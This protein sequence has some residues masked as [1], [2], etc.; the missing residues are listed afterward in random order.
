MASDE[1]KDDRETNEPRN[2]A[3]P[4]RRRRRRG[5]LWSMFRALR[6]TVAIFLILAAAVY[7][8]FETSSAGEWIGDVISRQ[9]EDGL[10]RSVSV[11][12]VSLWPTIPARLVVRDIRIANAPGA[13]APDFASV[14][15]IEVTGLLKSLAERRIDLGTIRVLHPKI[16]IEMMP[17]GSTIEDNIP[18][19]K[20]SGEDTGTTAKIDVQRILLQD[21]EVELID[22]RHDI[23]IRA[24]GITA[25]LL[26]DVEAKT[27]T[28]TIDA[29]VVRA[30]TGTVKYPPAALKTELAFASDALRF[31]SIE[32]T[33]GSAL[34]AEGEGR[35]GLAGT[36]SVDFNVRGNVDLAG[37]KNAFEIPGDVEFK[38]R[39]NATTKI[40]VRDT[41]R[42]TGRFDLPEVK[43]DV[44]EVRDGKGHF[45]QNDDGFS[46]NIDSGKFAGG[47]A[48]VEFRAP[49]KG[50]TLSVAI[51]H[52]DVRL[53]QLLAI[54][55]VESS[56][57]LG[58]ADGTLS[59]SW[60][61][62]DLL[63][64]T[65]KGEATLTADTRPASRAKYPLP[66]AGSVSYTI[67]GKKIDFEP[68]AIQTPQ[69]AVTITGTLGLEDLAT[70]L[71]AQV[72]SRNFAELDRI[73][74]DFA[75]ALGEK[76]FELL[77]L[78]GAGEI[79]AVVTGTLE[80]P[81]ADAT[82]SAD[83]F[84]YA[85]APLGHAE[86]DLRYDVPAE[87]LTFRR[88]T[89][90]A[91]GGTLELGKTIKL[92]PDPAEVIFDLD[93]R[94]DGWPV[95]RALK[96]IDLTLPISGR[97]TGG[98]HVSGRPSTG[99]VN[100]E[101]LAIKGNASQIRLNGL[102]GWTPAKNGLTFNLD[103]AT[104][105]TPVADIARLLELGEPPL[106]GGV[107]GTV[108]L[109][110]PLEKISGAG[111][112]AV[113]DGTISGEPFE[114]LT[115]DLVFDSGTVQVKNLDIRLAAGAIRG[116][117]AYSLSDER[118][119]FVVQS[120]SIDLKKLKGWPAIA[121][122]AEGTLVFSASGAGTAEHPEIVL[123][124]KVE[125]AKIAGFDL[126]SQDGVQLYFAFKPQG[127]TLRANVG[128]A[129][130]IEGTGAIDAATS[131]LRGSVR[132]SADAS[133]PL[134]SEISSRSDLPTKGK[135]AIDLEIAG[136]MKEIDKATVT[137]TVSSL[138]I[139]VATHTIRQA[140]R[141]Q[142]AIHDGKLVFDSFR[143]MFD[144]A[145]FRVDGTISLADQTVDILL[146]GTLNAELL[147]YVA[148]D[149]RAKGSIRISMAVSG[150]LDKPRIR[151]S[152]D[153]RDGEVRLAG[154]T[155]V[156]KEIN[157]SIVFRE[158]E[159]RIDS[160]N[161]N[162]GGGRVIAGGTINIKDAAHTQLRIS[163]QG[164]NVQIRPISDISTTGSFE[165]V[166]AGDLSEKIF[167][168]GKVDLSRV[169]VT[170]NV[171]VSGAMVDVFLKKKSTVTSIGAP[172]QERLLLAVDVSTRERAISIRNNLADM[173][174]SGDVRVTGSF[175]NPIVLGRIDLDEGGTFELRD[176]EYRIAHGQVNFQNPFRTDP[177]FDIT[178]ESRYQ[179][180]YDLTISLTGTI[181]RLDTTI[182]SDPPI[183][184]LSLLTLLGATG[185]SE[186]AKSTS[187]AL[188]EAGGSLIDKSVA[189][190]ISARVPFA[191]AVRLEGVTGP[192]P[193]VTIEKAISKE[194]R[195]I[196]TYTLNNTADNSEIVEWRVSP[197]LLILFTRDS[198]KDTRYGITSV[199]L[200]IRKRYGGVR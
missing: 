98:M 111:S 85:N 173:T 18:R 150:K 62:A 28:G 124:A 86:I 198:T 138:D 8:L 106:S 56:G 195:A 27:A 45:E 33:S 188:S 29:T 140:G 37:F 115:T 193:R 96:A 64:G 168:R 9:L 75:Q 118:F 19:W 177:Y 156:F 126:E 165:L 88:T 174:G 196:V 121:S 84:A 34:R 113:R 134:I 5:C 31:S 95:E 172:W 197:N 139:E 93:V 71:R 129:I 114:L 63:A 185:M 104:N 149:V 119:S 90:A 30:R 102:L 143:L 57:L 120:S 116:D 186:G 67:G 105:A 187:Q 164:K 181:D 155:Q 110:G 130:A 142:F 82:I 83:D 91:D 146:N 20:S 80:K 157:A 166:L 154:L 43:Y 179:N 25:D 66:V 192:D 24:G 47:T 39:L 194:L 101:N 54:W 42:V 132:I 148:S 13:T 144:G 180:E 2:D 21:A 176:V 152:A 53:E 32:V 48:S 50:D 40:S 145:P 46:L 77:G 60:A 10:G 117:A 169:L 68:L 189:S 15:R 74:F 79:K 184:D 161:A 178:A 92:P 58:V 99:E 167:L 147:N 136:N 108:H 133:S 6:T 109:E 36:T 182:T 127:F 52:R 158:D 69:S 4:E 94:A 12:R 141:P 97:A 190:L 51:R 135:L 162:V 70:N 1:H 3:T 171:D 49:S 78:G 183:E 123:D 131:D 59:Y 160:L 26:P 153:L 107:T 44:Y 72:K 103:V 55:G 81:V 17:E 7:V 125:K 137:G 23:S 76:K 87:T 22:R 170:K 89:F 41:V 14:E 35:I 199:D 200:T 112:I 175:A 61:G 122:S 65:G 128:T 11:G 191:D 151:G 73:A 38:G 16:S 159:I 163:V 100:F